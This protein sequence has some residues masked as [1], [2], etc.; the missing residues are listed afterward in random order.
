ML[1]LRGDP[2]RDQG[3]SARVLALRPGRSTRAGCS[4]LAHGCFG[5][6]RVRA[7]R[8]GRR[9]LFAWGGIFPGLFL[10]PYGMCARLRSFSLDLDFGLPPMVLG[11]PLGA[12]LT[13]PDLVRTRPDALFLVAHSS[14]P[15]KEGRPPCK[16]D[17]TL[18]EN[19]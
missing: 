5:P 13:F 16:A 9:R 17:T 12:T 18:H 7:R 6:G 15:I 8:F 11:P 2:S 4:R 1:G 3:S 14:I 19:H 10:S